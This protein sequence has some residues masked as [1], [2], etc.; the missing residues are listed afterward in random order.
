[1]W[2]KLLNLD[3][4][5][6]FIVTAICV[7]LPFLFPI[8]FPTNVTPPTQRIYDKIESVTEDG[9]AV[10]VSFDSDAAPLPELYP[11]A[12]SLIRHCFINNTKVILWGMN[13]QGVGI[14]QMALEDVKKDFPEK[15]SGINYVLIPYLPYPAIIIMKMGEDMHKAFN[16]DYY[17]VSIDSLPMMKDIRNFDQIALAVSLT[18][19]SAWGT[20][21]SFANQ[22]YGCKVA[23]GITAVGAPDCY[24]YLQT[25]QLVGMLG[26]MKG[27]AEYETLVEAKIAE[28]GL[29]FKT[30]KAACIGMDTQSVVHIVMII[31]IILG[32]IAYFVTR[33]QR[34]VA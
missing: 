31:F 24:P 13:M 32:N 34:N 22:K 9:P 21:V 26:G 5:W 27:A 11:M 8:G 20:W 17:G 16:T 29:N 19:G 7:I 14:I 3:R 33:R 15:K 1:M 4:R 30:R 6:I 25:G 10:I 12:V 28:K 2:N 18:G 23:T